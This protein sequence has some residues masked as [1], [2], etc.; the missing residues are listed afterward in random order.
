MAG[1]DHVGKEANNM[2]I[3]ATGVVG[4]EDEVLITNRPDGVP[5]L[6]ALLRY[7]PV[8]EIMAIMGCSKRQ[9][10][11]WQKGTHKPKG[12]RLRRLH[13]YIELVPR[14][15]RPVAALRL[16]IPSDSTRCY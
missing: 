11:Y 1:V 2:E 9:A 7:I 15:G 3:L 4:D 13:G 10:M 14:S 16:P 5:E 8:K 6:D 12:K